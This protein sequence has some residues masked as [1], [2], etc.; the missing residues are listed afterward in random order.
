MRLLRKLRVL[1]ILLA[2]SIFASQLCIVNANAAQGV[3]SA[4]IGTHLSGFRITDLDK[5]VAGKLLDQKARVR[6]NENVTW[7]IPVIW[8]DD[9]GITAYMAEPGRTYY[10]NFAFFIP[11]GY[12]IDEAALDGRFLVRLPEYL[13]SLFG[14]S[15]VLFATDADRGIT[16][17]S[18]AQAVAAL[19]ANKPIIDDSIAPATPA[20]ASGS[21]SDEG[22][23]G[24]SGSDTP[25]PAPYDPVSESVRIHCSQDVIDKFIEC[26]EILEDLVSLIKNKLEPQA[27]GLLKDKIRAFSNAY[28]EGT[29]TFGNYLGL[30]IYNEIGEIEGKPAPSGAL[31]YVTARY[32]TSEGPDIFKYCMGLD[33]A[34]FMT[35]DQTTGMWSFIEEEKVNLDN[36]IMHEMMHAYMY[37]Y[38]RRGMMSFNDSF[39]DW[40]TEG[41]AVCVENPYQ[42]RAFPLQ[43]LGAVDPDD[44]NTDLERFEDIVTY[45]SDSIRSRYLYKQGQDDD[46]NY[47]LKQSYH[48][49]NNLYSAYVSGYLAVVYLGYLAA[50][51][52]GECSATADNID[53]NAIRGGASSI[54]SMIHDGMSLDSVIRYI[55][56]PVADIEGAVSHYADAS[57]F[58]DK[59]IQGTDEHGYIFDTGNGSRSVLGSLEFTKNFLNFLEGHSDHGEG[60][61]YS[62]LANG[63][64]LR[65][66]QNYQSPLD[67]TVEPEKILYEMT[68]DPGAGEYVESSVDDT[69][70][71]DYT[72]G[73]TVDHFEPDADST[74]DDNVTQFPG[75]GER[76]TTDSI[77]AS[78]PS[79]ENG[80]ASSNTSGGSS[81]GSS[82]S[83]SDPVAGG[84]AVDNDIAPADAV[85]EN[86]V[87]ADAVPV[88]VIPADAVADVTCDG[89]PAANDAPADLQIPDVSIDVD[90]FTPVILPAE[91]DAILPED[92]SA[93]VSE[94]TGSDEPA[95]VPDGSPSSD[96]GSSSSDSGSSSSDEGSSDSSDDGGSDGSSESSE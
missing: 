96:S 67:W 2:V 64:I 81:S 59:F 11:E 48:T 73:K 13:I 57:D 45:N 55:S 76:D 12:Y 88:D 94:I 92:I 71:F 10:P 85:P 36:T 20:S 47:E 1:S 91:Q 41:I 77:A 5:P 54:L 34:S 51:H 82:D 35:Q 15:S 74:S 62:T 61:D 17:I 50:I 53:I 72:G 89:L 32:E 27:V 49:D 29:D 16:Y 70:A 19:A 84:S 26:P 80:S 56:T 7:E 23:S 18:F 65:A 37:D 75:S 28:E 83:A 78:V 69:K 40:F 3:E 90:G 93:P 22:E 95:P 14:E 44:W 79:A 42:F 66:D 60:K 68:D 8:T 25:A 52:D 31:A 58:E 87:P 63:S 9:R 30:Y 21:R 38:T 6:T 46:L 39:P 43:T 4:P 86:A 24:D 33:T